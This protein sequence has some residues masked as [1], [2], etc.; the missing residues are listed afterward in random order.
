MLLLTRGRSTNSKIR[1]FSGRTRFCSMP[2][3]TLVTPGTV[4]VK[5]CAAA[6]E[7]VKARKV[8]SGY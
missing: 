6:K 7:I 3:V 1:S 8:Q 2:F 4:D 5:I